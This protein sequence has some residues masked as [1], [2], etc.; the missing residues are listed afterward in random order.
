MISFPLHY[1]A[2]E[3]ASYNANPLRAILGLTVG[4]KVKTE[5]SKGKILV[6]MEAS[7]INPS[8]LAFVQGG[9]GVKKELPAVPGFE[10]CGRVVAANDDAGMSSWIGKRV[11]CFSQGGDDGTWASYFET[12]AAHIIE[13]PEAL[14]IA[15][16]ACYFVNPFTAYGLIHEAMK[17]DC[18]GLL[19]NA[20]GSRVADWLFHLANHHQ[21]PVVAVCRKNE[22]AEKL[23]QQGIENVVVSNEANYLED[24]RK[25]SK[26]LNINVLFDAVGGETGGQMASVL[27]KNGQHFVYGG[28]SNKALA[29]IDILQLIFNGLTI[30]GFHLSQWIKK[31]SADELENAKRF[32][33]ECMLS[34]KVNVPLEKIVAPNE[35]AMGLK[36]YLGNMSAGK[37]LLRF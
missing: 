23:Q 3:I 15:D 13:I 33:N 7:P 27:Q 14:E 30:K 9:Y 11:A 32:V 4:N 35:I 1:Q 8:D 10:G 21:L 36:H 18:K 6:K 34:K 20:A 17:N 16:A 25:I 12:D 29:D 26:K 22:T 5:L 31:T 37:V 28:L 2:I 24:L 19:I